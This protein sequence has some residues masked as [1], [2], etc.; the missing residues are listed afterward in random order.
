[1]SNPITILEFQKRFAT[2][3]DCLEHI[4]KL[5]WPNGFRCPNCEHD[6]GYK[7]KNRW[8]TQCAVCRHQ[9]SVTAG[10]IFHKTRVSLRK[11][12]WMIYMVAH[13]KGGASTLRLSQQLGLYYKTAWHMMQKIR[14]AM[15]RRDEEITLAGFIELDE[16]IIGPH[17]RKTGRK[18][19]ANDKNN[20]PGPRVR[21]LGLRPKNGSKRKTQTEVV[22]MVEREKDGAG[23]LAM[24]VVYKTTRDDLREAVEQK[25]EDSRQSFKTDA[26][27]SHFVVRS[28]GHNLKA[29]C[30]SNTPQSCVELPVVQLEPRA[31]F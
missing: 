2:E 20:K 22:V 4:E 28:M 19:R 1:M 30:L 3:D 12:F 27:Q 5:R 14:Y 15:G 25:V 26:I 10:T 21:K 13:D 18:R 9:T 31:P 8:I 24:K 29:M 23:N 11:W 6:L 7:L 17:A 16:A